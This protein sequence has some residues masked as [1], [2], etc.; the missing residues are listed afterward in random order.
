MRQVAQ[1]GE[2]VDL[3]LLFILHVR[4]MVSQEGHDP[5]RPELQTKR[6]LCRFWNVAEVVACLDGGF[7]TPREPLGRVFGKPGRY[8]SHEERRE[9]GA[10][11]AQ[12][13]GC[14]LVGDGG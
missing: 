6:A 12:H 5:G 4:G 14:Q 3:V 1:M 2:Y 7:A 8:L 10:N 13:C 9:A 11:V